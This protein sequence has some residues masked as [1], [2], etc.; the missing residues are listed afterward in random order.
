MRENS[1]NFS[2]FGGEIEACLF[3]GRGEGEKTRSAV[4]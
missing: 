3:E 4:A 1:R 2:F